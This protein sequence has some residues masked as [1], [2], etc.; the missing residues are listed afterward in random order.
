MWGGTVTSFSWGSAYGNQIVID[1]DVLPNGDPGLWAVYAHLK[2]EVVSPGDRVEAG[3]LIGYS[4]N[5]GNSS[6]N[7][8]HVEI[9]PQD[10]WVKGSYRD[11]QPWIDAGGQSADNG[12]HVTEHVYRSKCGYGEPTNGDDSSDTIKELQERL[13]RTSLKGGQELDITGR[14]DDE[15]DEEV[16]L[17]QDQI[18]GDPP[19]PAGAS[20]LGPNQFKAMFPDAV[21]TLH[22][23]GDPTV[24]N[25]S[26]E[27]PGIPVDPTVEPPSTAMGE[28]FVA[29]CALV[30]APVLY[31]ADWDNDDISGN[32]P[33]DPSYVLLHH[34]GGT[35]SLNWILY[36]G[37]YQ[38]IRLANFLVDRDG[39]LHVC[40]ARK[41]YHAGKGTWPGVPTDEMN[42]YSVGIEI[43]SKG[44]T[45]DLTD[46][47]ILTVAQFC[48]GWMQ[49]FSI[50]LDQV[51]NHKDWSSTGKPDT[52]YD[53]EWWHQQIL[54]WD[55]ISIPPE[56][57]EPEPGW[58]DHTFGRYEWYSGKETA[59]VNLD[60]DGEWHKVLDAMPPSDISDSTEFHLLYVRIA[61]PGNRT[62][63]RTI[64]SKWVRSDGDA[65]AY[66]SPEWT[67]GAKDSVAK[68]N[69]HFESGS[70][71]G[72]QWYLKV[73]GGDI[74]YSTI[75]G[76]THILYQDALEVASAAFMGLGRRL[77]PVFGF[78]FVRIG[79]WIKNPDSLPRREGTDGRS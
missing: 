45:Q 51:L 64:E 67:P 57:E 25:G 52:R 5:T 29:A 26:P 34:T 31:E 72:G 53:I 69:V 8:L 63:S 42:D 70:G 55:D 1:H 40:A 73:S 65:T 38:P 56:P 30:S 13:N 47:Q 46:A 22:D 71:L 43:E 10:H 44:E 19:D 9:Q 39:T 35:N 37:D 50:D 12:P 23:D 21:Y 2:N 60:N 74:T 15:T 33:W 24:A 41:T 59:E 32:G 48:D 27:N 76:K 20:Y 36:G 78:I 68:F 79:R 6:G 62:A 58:I 49:E 61:L 28:R 66:A 7:H 16:R 77:G 4:D 18:V 11:P 14:Y 17:W 3:Q 54:T 75:Y